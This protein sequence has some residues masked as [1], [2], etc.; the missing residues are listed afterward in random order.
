V[1]GRVCY[2]DGKLDVERGAGRFLARS[3]RITPGSLPARAT[4]M[5]RIG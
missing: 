4:E 1:N 2:S 3:A 5:G